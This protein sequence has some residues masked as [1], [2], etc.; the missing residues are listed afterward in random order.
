MRVA[1]TV[2]VPAG[3][4]P[5]VKRPSP[6]VTALRSAT[7]TVTPARG[8]WVAPSTTLPATVPVLCALRPATPTRPAASARNS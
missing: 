5:M 1:R 8:S 7:F 6:P 4:A 3:T 2:C